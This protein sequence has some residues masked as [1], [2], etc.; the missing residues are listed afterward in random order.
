[1][2]QCCCRERNGLVD[3]ESPSVPLCPAEP[4]TIRVRGWLFLSC[5]TPR[6]E[7][8]PDRPAQLTSAAT[9]GGSVGGKEW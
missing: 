1:M 8:S 4:A 7:T 6:F 3:T 5:F 2:P 9:V